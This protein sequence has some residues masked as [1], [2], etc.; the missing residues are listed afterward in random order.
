M[1]KNGFRVLDSDMHVVE[2]VDL[3]PRYI[4]PA[5]RDRAPVGLNRHQRDLGVTVNGVT[6]GAG[7]S[8]LARN[9]AKQVQMQS[10]ESLYAFAA[11]RGWDAAS[12]LQAMDAEG[13]DVAVLF[14]SRGLF[15][16]GLD[17]IE[18]DRR[19]GLDPG[20]AAA[21]ARAYNDWMRDFCAAG[22]SRLYGAGMIAPHDIEASV[23]ETRRCVK[24]LGFKA[25]F[26]L[27]GCVNKR[28]WHH[29]AYDPIWAECER[30]DIPIVFHGG[31]KDLLTPDFGLEVF[32]L[33]MMFHTFSHP[34][35]PMSALVSMTAG[36][37][38][39]RYPTLR[40]GYLEGNCS[41]APWLLYRLD[42]QYEWRGRLE[43]PQLTMRP[44]EYF[45]RNCFVSVEADEEP[46]RWYV[47]ALGD[48]NVVFSTDYPHADA[49][50]P[51]AVERMLQLPVSDESK[52][53][54]LWDNCAR[55]YKL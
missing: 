37:V 31:G 16:L 7:E 24:D 26:V 28:P 6:L 43:N 8:T 11:E 44:S 2:P 45:R 34:L 48:E 39:E 20:Y 4:D 47:Q 40:A 1:A 46:V 33:V 3:W 29:P 36:G 41:W 10:K 51:H 38:F 15:V 12:Q 23:A 30:L 19:T 53:K 14:P 27:P 50:F 25:M 54:F 35:G 22:R 13:I 32:D 52:R 42:E 5:Y 49:K 9:R 18:V 21:I 55:L 17:S